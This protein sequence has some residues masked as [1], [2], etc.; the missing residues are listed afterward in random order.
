MAENPKCSK[1]IFLKGPREG[2]VPVDWLWYSGETAFQVHFLSKILSSFWYQLRDKTDFSWQ[3]WRQLHQFYASLSLNVLFLIDYS[4]NKHH[5]VNRRRYGYFGSYLW[6]PLIWESRKDRSQFV[7]LA[8]NDFKTT[9][10]RT[11]H[12][13]G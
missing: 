13:D 5:R 1:V 6:L 2:T 7:G 10:L 4:P 11:N 9:V 12:T 3:L 8:K